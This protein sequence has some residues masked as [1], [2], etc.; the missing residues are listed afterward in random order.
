M[1]SIQGSSRSNGSSQRVTDERSLLADRV[2]SRAP[3]IRQAILDRLYGM[4]EEAPT[5]DAEYLRG[6]R[7]AVTCGVDYGIALLK[8]G[9]ERDPQVPIALVVQARLAA[10]QGISLEIV[11]GRYLAGKK[12]LA[13]SILEEAVAGGVRDPAVLQWALADHETAFDQLLSTVAEEYRREE[14]RCQRPS[15][16]RQLKPI[17]RLLAGESVDPSR[18]DYDLSSHHLGLVVGSAEARQIIRLLAAETD[19][20]P[21]V[22]RTTEVETWAW[23]GSREILDPAAVGRLA[24]RACSPSAPIAM[25]EPALGR[26]GWRLTHR[27]ARAAFAIAQASPAAFARY[28]EVAIVIG[29][30]ENPLLAT[31]LQ[32]LYLSPLQGGRNSGAVLR[33]TLRAYF[34]ADRNSKSAASALGVSRQAVANRLSQVETRVGQPLSMCADAVDAALRMEELGFL[35]P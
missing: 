10:R 16:D 24:A 20:R 9:L 28:A 4:E 26:N 1:W 5:R 12:L 11:I 29:A 35:D 2:R 3:E 31:S 21:L 34:N 8:E 22:V 18:L 19:C 30:T 32:E 15:G 33:A 27:Q 13:H 14:E 23:L 7:E 17:R 25:G 6:L